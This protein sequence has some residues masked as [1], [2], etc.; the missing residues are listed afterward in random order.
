MGEGVEESTVS[1]CEHCET[2]DSFSS[3]TSN[4][5][6]QEIAATYFRCGENRPV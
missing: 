5:T 6:Q 1:Q 2:V 3:L 4:I